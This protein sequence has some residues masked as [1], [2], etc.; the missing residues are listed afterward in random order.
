MASIINDPGDRKRILFF[1]ADD[2]RRCIRLGKVS[3]ETAVEWKGYVEDLDEASRNRQ[4]P[5]KPTRD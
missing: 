3:P 4:L 1:A 5:A 2:R